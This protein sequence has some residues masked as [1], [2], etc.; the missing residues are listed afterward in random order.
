[1]TWII[2]AVSLMAQA[3]DQPSTFDNSHPNGAELPIIAGLQPMPKPIG[4]DSELPPPEV[5]VPRHVNNVKKWWAYEK[6]RA[7]AQI[8]KNARTQYAKELKRIES[9]S[10]RARRKWRIAAGIP[11]AKHTAGR[12]SGKK[13]FQGF[14]LQKA[15]HQ[16][17]RAPNPYTN[18]LY[19]R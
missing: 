11:A 17:G 19:L 12:L 1:M 10:E 3:T 18:P 9:M 15:L 4:L 7:L 8:A 16:R 5:V 2:I 6:R 13:A 14:L